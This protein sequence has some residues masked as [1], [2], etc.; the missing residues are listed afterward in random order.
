MKRIGLVVL[1][2]TCFIPANLLAGSGDAVGVG[3]IAKA[4]STKVYTDSSGDAVDEILAKGFPVIAFDSAS[5]WGG[6]A[7]ASEQEKDGRLHV[8]YWKNG[9]DADGG[10]N[11]AWI[12]PKDVVKFSFSCCGDKACTG[13]KAQM[14]ATRSYTDCFKQALSETLTK[15]ST[16][17][18][19]VA[20]LEKLKLQLEIEK[21][22]LEQEKLKASQK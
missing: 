8:R 11:T 4:D 15:S 1:L 12:D 22:K 16:P 13:I 2:I 20:E 6:G 3:Y 10:E 19:S 14:F 9:K 5:L 7:M 18:T 17:D 21:L